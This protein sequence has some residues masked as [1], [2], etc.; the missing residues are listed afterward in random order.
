M[1]QHPPDSMKF[2]ES[3]GHAPQVLVLG[4]GPAGAAAATILA[5]EGHAPTLVRPHSPPG[6]SLAESIPP[7]ASP[8]L[9]EI[10]ALTAIGSAG[11][12]PNLGNT[13][14][15]AGRPRRR[16]VFRDGAGGFHV[17]R[18]RLEAVLLEV[19]RAAGATLLEGYWAR[20]VDRKN[21]IW[22]IT[23]RGVAGGASVLRAP[24]VIDATGRHG[25]LAR[26]L[27]RVRDA[28][29]MT[30]ALIAR[31][32]GDP[33]ALEGGPNDTLVESY[34]DG[35]AW[36]IPLALHARCLTV[37]VDP[38]HAVVVEARTGAGVDLGRLMRTELAKAPHLSQLLGA[39]DL[40]PGAWACPAS[41]YTS[42]RFS[43]EGLVLAGDAGSFIDPLSSYGVKKA[44]ASGWRAG[45]AVHTALRDSN[46][47]ATALGYHDAREREV[48]E[49]Y[50]AHSAS[51]YADAAEAHRHPF[52]H[53]RASA[54]AGPPPA[55]PRGGAASWGSA[56][57]PPSGAAP[58]DD[59]DAVEGPVPRAAVQ[60]A[61]ERIRSADALGARLGTTLRLVEAPAVE[62][63]LIVRDAH[64]ASDACPEGLRYHRS[65]DLRRLVRL[66]PEH[67]E[68]PALWSEY[69]RAGPVV[70]LPEF[71]TALAVAFAAGFLER[72]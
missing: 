59:P 44:L 25:L 15:W 9:A 57:R 7:S 33:S 64:L 31:W 38:R 67:D 36:S 46:M 26:R 49:R 41:P 68:V 40:E 63:R 23:C 42:S 20:G 54:A 34:E 39:A 61:Y 51:F 43:D 3:P 58:G 18:Q 45:V 21:G 30:I 28:A 6:G 65:V 70:E 5:L 69:N 37:M 55:A 1:T 16:E 29:P 19:A 53:E 62:G 11:F 66:A 4:G 50:R 14:W 52:W 10:G 72:D 12:Q 2:A 24:W 48:F 13:V 56:A 35:W 17:E 8:L 71:L 47:T 60:A 27:G 32:R 22:S